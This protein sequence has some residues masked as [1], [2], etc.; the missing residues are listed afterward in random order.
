MADIRNYFPGGAGNAAPPINSGLYADA[1]ERSKLTDKVPP[2]PSHTEGGCV[3]FNGPTFGRNR[4]CTVPDAIE[5]MKRCQ[6]SLH[7]PMCP[8]LLGRLSMVSLMMSG[9]SPRMFVDLDVD[10]SPETQGKLGGREQ[11]LKRMEQCAK[12]I[13]S[14]WVSRVMNLFASQNFVQMMQDNTTILKDMR[15]RIAT[16]ARKDKVGAHVVVS[17]LPTPSVIMHL[18]V[19]DSLQDQKL[20]DQV[21]ALGL[22][23][24]ES[25]L[26]SRPYMHAACHLRMH[27][28]PKLKRCDCKGAWQECSNQKCVKG[29]CLVEGSVY[30]EVSAYKLVV[31]RMGMEWESV[32]KTNKVIDNSIMFSPNLDWSC[33]EASR[34]PHV[35]QLKTCWANIIS[36]LI[37][38]EDKKCIE[39]EGQGRPT[40]PMYDIDFITDHFLKPKEKADDGRVVVIQ[41][42]DE[43]FKTLVM[44]LSKHCGERFVPQ[45][46]DRLYCKGSRMLQVAR[47][48]VEGSPS[49]GCAIV[50]KDSVGSVR[51]WG[52]L[53]HRTGH[54]EMPGPLCEFIPILSKVTGVSAVRREQLVSCSQTQAF[55]QRD[56]VELKENNTNARIQGTGLIK[57]DKPRFLRVMKDDR[58]FV[59]HVCVE[60]GDDGWVSDSAIKVEDSTVSESCISSVGKHAACLSCTWIKKK[61]GGLFQPIKEV[62]VKTDGLCTMLNV[63]RIKG[64]RNAKY[65]DEIVFSSKHCINANNFH[66]GGCSGRIRAINVS[67]TLSGFLFECECRHKKCSHG[68]RRLGMECSEMFN[69]YQKIQSLKTMEDGNGGGVD[70]D[71]N[72]IQDMFDSILVKCEKSELIALKSALL[73]PPPKRLRGAIPTTEIMANTTSVMHCVNK[74]EIDEAHVLI[75]P[76]G[77]FESRLQV[78][79]PDGPVLRP[80]QLFK[81][82]YGE[83]NDDSEKRLKASLQQW[84]NMDITYTAMVE[85]MKQLPHEL[86]TDSVLKVDIQKLQRQALED[87]DSANQSASSSFRISPINN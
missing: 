53:W 75:L 51:E 54:D 12:I 40:D 1:V 76:R 37:S 27:G 34:M 26:D 48:A 10:L 59:L 71:T 68:L 84:E 43:R 57:A 60:K 20:C 13:I 24:L 86:H 81:A 9:E 56:T 70:V 55:S 49:G 65:W 50:P 63:E 38:E 77:P 42:D 83:G 7:D 78:K 46:G 80:R 16:S 47:V 39:T 33:D 22:G 5:Y 3:R 2:R 29:W 11:V 32:E 30:K 44:T 41:K 69:S 15:I 58:N 64:K 21:E 8:A 6:Q 4:H 35:N 62:F 87:A 82:K 14:H 66:H 72:V 36:K 28:C 79:L 18:L 74:K 52:I 23:S 85:A 17:G 25:M 19:K 31:A 67:R 45:I 73:G 61:Q